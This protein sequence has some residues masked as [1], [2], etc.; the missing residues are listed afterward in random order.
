MYS[1][2]FLVR[3]VNRLICTLNNVYHKGL[4]I[5]ERY[6]LKAS[7]IRIYNMINQGT[8]SPES[9][10]FIQKEVFY[11]TEHL[12]SE[13]IDFLNYSKEYYTS[14]FRMLVNNIL[15]MYVIKKDFCNIHSLTN[16]MEFSDQYSSKNIKLYFKI[17]QTHLTNN[18]DDFI[19]IN[20]LC[21][22][23]IGPGDFIIKNKNEENTEFYEYKEPSKKNCELMK[24]LDTC[25]DYQFERETDYK[26]FERMKRQKELS[27]K[28]ID[29]LNASECLNVLYNISVNLHDD[30]I[31]VSYNLD[32]L[33]TYYDIFLAAIKKKK[34]YDI[35]HIDEAIDLII[36]DRKAIGCIHFDFRIDDPD[37]IHYDYQEVIINPYLPQLYNFISKEKLNGNDMYRIV[38]GELHILTIVNYELLFQ[39]FR[40]AGYK[41][42]SR[43]NGE[44]L[45]HKN[46]LYYKKRWWIIEKDGIKWPISNTLVYRLTCAFYTSNDCLIFL[47]ELFDTILFFQRIN[48]E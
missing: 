40:E 15:W 25:D 41:V 6:R 45:S 7:Y 14:V 27:E 33:K 35:I 30:R 42:Y 1:R 21:K 36:I 8:L 22:G 23:G 11:I 16:H 39:K 34:T 38:S 4:S 48:N 29:N 26:Q 5:V 9:V 2:N 17:A 20:D 44:G 24:L 12:R 32:G 18:S 37:L 13:N 47:E 3:I 43:K 28:I 31:I 46:N 10:L 19:I